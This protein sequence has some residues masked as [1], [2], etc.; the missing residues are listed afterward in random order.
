MKMR[1]S[2]LMVKMMNIR[3]VNMKEWDSIILEGCELSNKNAKKTA[4]ILNDSGIIKIIELKE[5]R[6]SVV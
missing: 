6:K 2:L 5:D 4:R 3:T 1:K